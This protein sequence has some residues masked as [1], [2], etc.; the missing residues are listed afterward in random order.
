MPSIKPIPYSVALAVAAIAHPGHSLAAS[1]P[2]LLNNAIWDCSATADGRWDCSQKTVVGAK[3]ISATPPIAGNA[4]A[5]ARYQSLDWVQQ[6]QRDHVCQGR[7]VEPQFKVQ[8]DEEKEGPP[9]YLDAGSSK[10][11]LGGKT[12]L[13]N[14]VNFRQGQ[15]RLSAESID[16]NQSEDSAHLKGDVVFREP[17]L[18][19]V[20]SEAQVSLESQ[21]GSFTN[22][23]FVLHESHLRGKADKVKR[24]ADGTMNLVEGD[25]TFCPPGNEDWKISAADIKLDHES[26]FGIAQ[27]ATLNVGPVPILYLPYFSFPISDKRKSGFLY[28]SISYSETN[29]ADIAAP[30]YFNLAPNYDNTLTPRWIGNRGAMLENEFRYLNSMS[31]NRV[32]V[33]YL[34][35]DDLYGDDRWLTQLQHTGTPAP[36]W[37][38]LVDFTAVSD[39]EYFGDIKTTLKVDQESHLNQRALVSY[40]GTQWHASAQLH[41]YQSISTSTTPYEKLPQLQLNGIHNYKTGEIR[42]TTEYVYFDRDLE[43]LAASE[44]ATGHR[45]HFTPSIRQRYSRSWGYLSPELRLWNTEYNLSNQAS[46]NSNTPSYSIPVASIDGGLYFDRDMENGGTHT[47][48]PRIF[49]LYV[50]D[51]DQNEAPDFDTSLLDFSYLSLFRYNRFS[52]RDRLGDAQ[53]ISLGITNR[54]IE[55]DGFERAYFSIGQAFYFDDR[56]VVLSGSPETASQSDIAI[57]AAWNYNEH[58]RIRLDNVLAYSDLDLK[59]TNLR[60]KYKSDLNH[61]LYFRYRFEEDVR[62]Q[63]D[64]HVIWPLASNWTALGRWQ[65]NMEDGEDLEA[66]L[67]IEYESCCWKLQ[68]TGRRWLTDTDEYNNGIFLR[69]ILKGLGSLSGS[70]G[71]LNDITGFE[72]RDE[73]DDF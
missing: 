44:R 39:E 4:K 11:K 52:G 59:E 8:G 2:A 42:Y 61:Q 28:P 5:L 1:T 20:A 51:K 10:T 16:V 14:G 31:S 40:Y 7:Y 41:A 49:F 18:L 33:S 30:Y 29:G 63:T 65:R 15:R 43:G 17:G 26:G 24:N 38:S 73:Q 19:V 58:M 22:A 25:Y 72:E 9:I 12:Q 21:Q 50:P 67:G 47:L 37:H 54:F 45:V 66:V 34:P 32:D 46:G 23:Q 53:K 56:D 55:P 27:K 69:F 62:D 64:L 60:L 68:L 57:E 36:Q 70:T 48:E 71:F 13:R 6:S 3:S 35:D